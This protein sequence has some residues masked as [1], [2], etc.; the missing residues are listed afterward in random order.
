MATRTLS[1]RGLQRAE[2][3]HQLAVAPPTLRPTISHLASLFSDGAAGCASEKL[4][5]RSAMECKEGFLRLNTCD[6]RTHQRNVMQQKKPRQSNHGAV[7]VV[8]K[9]PQTIAC[10]DRTWFLPSPSVGS[11]A[12]LSACTHPLCL[13]PPDTNSGWQN[14]TNQG[15]QWRLRQMITVVFFKRLFAS[16]ALQRNW[17]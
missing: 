14:A 13:E 16:T 12:S 4:D 9:S 6:R 17:N 3:N 1:A 10:V 15:R 11:A 8:F 7:V 5:V 2:L